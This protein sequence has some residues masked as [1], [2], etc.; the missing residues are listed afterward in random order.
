MLVYIIAIVNVQIKV[1]YLQGEG[2]ILP[3]IQQQYSS[4]STLKVVLTLFRPS[5][6]LLT[7]IQIYLDWLNG[8]RY[9]FVD[10]K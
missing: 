7:N 3:E 2:D 9:G 6:R 5:V 10:K 1:S 4:K 8:I